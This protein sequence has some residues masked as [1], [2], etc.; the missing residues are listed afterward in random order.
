[1]PSIAPAMRDRP[2]SLESTCGLP[3]LNLR[4]DDVPWNCFAVGFRPPVVDA[5]G[6]RVVTRGFSDGEHPPYGDFNEAYAPLGGTGEGSLL[7]WCCTVGRSGSEQAAIEVH[8]RGVVLDQQVIAYRVWRGVA[9][10]PGVERCP[11]LH[12]SGEY[13]RELREWDRK[14]AAKGP[15]RRKLDTLFLKLWYS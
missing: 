1:M 14:N 11:T 10:P 8:L 12:L 2:D 5:D 3:L 7:F 4:A 15:L 13:M 6:N 9:P